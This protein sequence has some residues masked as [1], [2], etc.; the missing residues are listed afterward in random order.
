MKLRILTL[1]FCSALQINTASAQ[2]LR[3]DLV[4][5]QPGVAPT[6]TV[7]PRRRRERERCAQPALLY[8]GSERLCKRPIWGDHGRTLE[9]CNSSRAG[10]RDGENIVRGYTWHASEQSASL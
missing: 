6:T 10:R 2:Y 9:R 4:S 3:T 8:S 5:N 7:W 1:L